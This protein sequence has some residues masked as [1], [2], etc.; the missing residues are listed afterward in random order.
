MPFWSRKHSIEDKLDF[1]FDKIKKLVSINVKQPPFQRTIVPERVEELKQIFK[2]DFNPIVPL[3][4]CILNDTYYIIDGQH[5]YEVYKTMTDHSNDKVPCCYIRV[6]TMKEVE[7]CFFTINDRLP[8]NDMWLQPCEIKQIIIDTYMYFENNYPEMFRFKKKRSVPRPYIDKE[9]FKQKISEIFTEEH[10]L[11]INTSKDLINLLLILEEQYSRI[12]PD[13][14]PAIEGT[15]NNK[16]ITKLRNREQHLHFGLVKHDWKSHLIYGIKENMNGSQK[17]LPRSQILKC[18]ENAYG[19]CSRAKCYV[20]D[21]H[22]ITLFNC[23]LGHIQ[24]KARGGE[25]TIENIIP[26]CASCNHEMRTM[27]LEDYK[28]K[29]YGKK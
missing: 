29:Y 18:W 16:L 19:N 3:Y 8:L 6:E 28:Q 15:D 25:T 7:D 12:D 2:T 21:I 10:N 20:C 9:I 4:I 22:Q 5:R 1:E 17:T 14:F 23:H 11:H 13:Q 24:A 27:N 26:I